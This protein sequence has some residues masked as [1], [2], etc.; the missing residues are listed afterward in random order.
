[1]KPQDFHFSNLTKDEHIL[2]IV[3]RHWFDIFLQYLPVLGILALTLMSF[4]A[5]PLIFDDF[6]SE[7]SIPIFFFI[8][9][10]ILILLW[11]YCFLIWTDYYLDIWIITTQRVIN[12]EQKGLFVR[13]VS[14]LQ[15][16][17]IEDITTEVEGFFSTILNYGNVHAQTAAEETR[18]TFHNVPNPYKIRARLMEQHRKIIDK[19]SYGS[20]YDIPQK[21]QNK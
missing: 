4:L 2:R 11:L 7:A 3:H 15:F 19:K 9:T 1:M 17:K 5:I 18:F 6:T 10:F 13:H 21:Q 16:S 8:Q 14:E 20:T 12:I